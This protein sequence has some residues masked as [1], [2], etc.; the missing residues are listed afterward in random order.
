MIAWP[1]PFSA[2][3]SFHSRRLLHA[4]A[5]VV[6]DDRRCN[7]QRLLVHVCW[8]EAE[9]AALGTTSQ[10]S[11]NTFKRRAHVFQDLF[12]LTNAHSEVR[13]LRGQGTLRTRVTWEHL[14]AAPQLPLRATL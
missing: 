14:T 12:V 2:S 8:G 13:E 3:H 4:D 6:P 11:F 1:V 7:R 10:F 9:P 5:L